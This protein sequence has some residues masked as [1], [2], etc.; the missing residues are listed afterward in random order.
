MA[1]H[2]PGKTIC[3]V[4][5]AASSETLRAGGFE[6][7][8]EGEGT[9]AS[10]FDRRPDLAEL[11]V[12]LEAMILLRGIVTE[13]FD[14]IL[15]DPPVRDIMHHGQCQGGCLGFFFQIDDGPCPWIVW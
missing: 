4:A 5:A 1:P 8:S 10:S 6:G 12:Q 3:F 9:L 7:R 15:H 14:N 13:Y 2:T 11:R